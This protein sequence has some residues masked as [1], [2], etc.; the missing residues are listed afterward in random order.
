MKQLFLAIFLCLTLLNTISIFAQVPLPKHDSVRNNAQTDTAANHTVIDRGISGMLTD[1]KE[2]DET[3]L[4]PNPASQEINVIYN[5]AADIKSIAVYNLIGRIQ[6]VYKVTGNNSANLQLEG[7][8][9]GIYFVRL[10]NS[11]GEAV[12]T[13]KFTKQ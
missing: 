11:N 6:T 3:Q 7:M 10:F 8:P 13:K 1:L 5:A 4:Y 2:T 9:P 12:V